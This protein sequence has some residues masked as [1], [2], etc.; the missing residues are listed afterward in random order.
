MDANESTAEDLIDL[1]LI[2][3]SRDEKGGDISFDEY[4]ANQS[5]AS[6]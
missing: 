6:K 4:K 3:E 1:R 2:E 5:R